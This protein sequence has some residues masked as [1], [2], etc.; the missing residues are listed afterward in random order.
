MLEL[1]RS[2]PSLPRSPTAP[3]LVAPVLRRVSQMFFSSS[4]FLSEP[5]EAVR[6]ADANGAAGAGP[7][8]GEGGC[9]KR[10]TGP[11]RLGRSA[12]R[13]ALSTPSDIFFPFR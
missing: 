3:R 13:R 11:W 1:V 8:E 7:G 12:S 9:D 10:G 6:G 2:E 5:S 4:P